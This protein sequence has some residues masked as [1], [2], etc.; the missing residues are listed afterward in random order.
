MTF[1]GRML[2]CKQ[3]KPSK[4]RARLL[5]TFCFIKTISLKFHLKEFKIVYVLPVETQ[6]QCGHTRNKHF[7]KCDSHFLKRLV[8]FASKKYD[9]EAPMCQDINASIDK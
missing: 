5:K 4:I 8:L 3:T 6:L 2:S 1:K 9:S 7:L